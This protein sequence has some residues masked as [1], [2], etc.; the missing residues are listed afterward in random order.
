MPSHDN[1]TYTGHVSR[2]LRINATPLTF[3]Q[4]LSTLRKMYRSAHVAA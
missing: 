1:L 4:F 2:C 3:P